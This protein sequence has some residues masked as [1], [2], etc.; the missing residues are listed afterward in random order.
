VADLETLRT[1]TKAFLEAIPGPSPAGIPARLD[2]AYQAVATEVAKIDAPAGGEVNWKAV[3]A[4]AGELIRTRSKDIVLA[5]FLA[6]GLQMTAGIDGLATGLGLLADLLDTYWDTA[7]PEL[8]R[9]RG[10]ANAVQWLVERMRVSLPEAHAG[11]RDAAAV[12]TLDVAVQ[13]LAEVV[14]AR[15]ADQA[16]AMGQLQ[17]E[18]ARLKAEAERATAPPP[19]PAAAPVPGPAAA[20]TQASPAATPAPAPAVAPGTL[21]GPEQAADYLR[22][23]GTALVSAAN[24]LRRADAADPRAYRLMRTG[25]WLHLEAPPPAPSGKTSILPPPAEQREQLATLAQNARWPALVDAAEAALVRQ[26]LWLD[27]HRH[28]AQALAGLGDG[29]AR[30]REAVVLGL[31]ALLARLP[32]IASLSFED[33]TPLAD[34]QTRTWIAEE[35]LPRATPPAPAPGAAP[36]AGAAPGADAAALAA[37][38]KQLAGGK[39]AEALATLRS[40]EA[41]SPDGRGRF[42][43][44]LE[45]AKA[46][47]GAGLKAVARATY[48]ELDREV[49]AHRLEDWEPALASEV[50]KGAIAATRA[51]G[52][53]PRAV[54]DALVSQY[55]RLCRLDPAAAHEVWP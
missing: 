30:A 13:R 48:D 17:D 52:S 18:V 46:A 6:H 15:F 43:V 32:A 36:A 50:L 53:D 7:Y 2:P 33:G 35:V 34:P 38:R 47:A 10:R 11:A 25:L 42:R 1:R 51:L 5:A 3:V 4:G 28:T 22:D 14:R 49:V 27:L 44:R 12:A 20:P 29:H 21:A 26:R 8:K 16:P 54:K 55:Q 40:L 41:A 31:R 24:V 37:A 45:L 23:V 39:I 9:L 19:P